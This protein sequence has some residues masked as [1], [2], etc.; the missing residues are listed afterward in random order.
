MM[1]FFFFFFFFFKPTSHRKPSRPLQTS[2]P[3]RSLEVRYGNVVGH[4]AVTALECNLFFKWKSCLIWP[5]TFCQYLD[6]QQ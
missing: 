6:R 1:D 5:V 2:F 4:N 3:S